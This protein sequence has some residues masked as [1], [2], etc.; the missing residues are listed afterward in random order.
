MSR[1]L[2]RRFLAIFIS[3]LCATPATSLLAQKWADDMFKVK[4]YNFGDVSRNAK[5]EYE[6]EVYNPYIEDIHIR[7]VS[8]SCSCTTVSVDKSTLKTYETAK[9]KAHYNT[10]RFTGN[11]SATLSVVID[12]PFYAT[13]QLQ[14]KGNIRSDIIFQ[15][16]EVN[17]GTVPS[18]KAIEK[19]VDMTY[20]GRSNWQITELK[21]SNRNIS[22]ELTEMSRNYGQV[23]YRLKVKL[24]PDAPAGY[25]NDR[26]ILIS[27]EGMNREIP[28]MVQGVVKQGITAN[29]SKLIVGNLE[30]GQVVTKRIVLRADT[31]F[32]IKNVSCPN[33]QYSFDF[34]QASGVTQ[35]HN[36]HIITVTFQAPESVIE[37]QLAD[38]IRIITDA[39]QAPVEVQTIA[40]VLT[41]AQEKQV[42][43]D[44]SQTEINISG[45][46][47]QN[48]VADDTGSLSRLAP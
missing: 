3:L 10:D 37:H 45:D 20:L 41:P 34:T 46:N 23:K 11:K 9:V 4:E 14:V 38:T 6:F 47:D 33:K 27:N 43:P 25:I 12:K 2:S 15:P 35:S 19:I 24:A 36:V 29:P 40:K 39:Q 16:N 48:T 31:P 1:N 18:G 7:S 13:V 8:S 17:F 26:L 28:I 42:R 5:A 21:S 32:A 22:A 44:E 30:P